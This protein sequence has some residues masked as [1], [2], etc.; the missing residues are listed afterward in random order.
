MLTNGS[1]HLTSQ[2]SALAAKGKGLPVGQSTS[3]DLLTSKILAAQDIESRRSRECQARTVETIQNTSEKQTLESKSLA[4]QELTTRRLILDKLD[5]SREA[6]YFKKSEE[7]LNG[8]QSY[9]TSLS[10]TWKTFQKIQEM[11]FNAAQVS[12]ASNISHG[13]APTSRVEIKST[14]LLKVK[15]QDVASDLLI[16]L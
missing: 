1:Q 6:C 5:T 10:K 15:E 7:A 9:H 3:V 16:R 8:I 13:S 2:I 4:M 11:P 12:L 14:E